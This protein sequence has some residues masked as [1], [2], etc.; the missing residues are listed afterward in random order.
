[1][2]IL[3]LPYKGFNLCVCLAIHLKE[4][5]NSPSSNINEVAYKN[6]H[7]IILYKGFFLIQDPCLF[8]DINFQKYNSSQTIM[9]MLKL[10][11]STQVTFDID[12]TVSVT[13]G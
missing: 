5:Q 9:V 13:V 6:I 4:Q 3:I 7:N 10:T 12:R 11:V 8:P 1:M 2:R